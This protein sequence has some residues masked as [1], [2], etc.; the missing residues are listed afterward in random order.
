MINAEDLLKS[1]PKDEELAYYKKKKIAEEVLKEIPFIESMMKDKAAIGVSYYEYEC[2]NGCMVFVN[3]A[4]TYFER[5]G[6]K[7]EIAHTKRNWSSYVI[8]NWGA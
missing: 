3:M 5:F 4:K 8:I 2:K 1:T 6:Y 7:V